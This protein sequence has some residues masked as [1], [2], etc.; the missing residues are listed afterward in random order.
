MKLIIENPP[1][2]EGTPKEIAELM[3]TLSKISKIDAFKKLNEE[4]KEIEF[5]NDTNSETI[6]RNK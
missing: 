4:I 6:E 2:V 3:D 5:S 1:Y